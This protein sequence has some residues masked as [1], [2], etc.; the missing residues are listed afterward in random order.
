M[1]AAL[2]AMPVDTRE[3]VLSQ[4]DAPRTLQHVKNNPRSYDH[5]KL[6]NELM[7]LHERIGDLV[8]QVVM[9][10]EETEQAV[11]LAEAS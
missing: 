10:A 1:V 2:N 6:L 8:V 3:K 9:G 7:G 5:D 11:P 4:V